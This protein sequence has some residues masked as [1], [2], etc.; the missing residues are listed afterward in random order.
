MISLSQGHCE[1]V[2]LALAMHLCPPEIHSDSLAALTMLGRWSAWPTRK[3]IECRDRMEVR[4]VLALAA[5]MGKVPQLRKVKAHD[6]AIRA[7]HPCAAGNDVADRWAKRAASEEGHPTW[8]VDMG[9]CV[10]D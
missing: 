6:E 9:P 4:L 7:G 5:E 10:G 1:L 2:A 8:Q 3:V